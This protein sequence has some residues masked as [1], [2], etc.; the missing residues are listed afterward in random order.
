MN[1]LTTVLKSVQKNERKKRQAQREGAAYPEYAT[2]VSGES[3]SKIK[4]SV[5]LTECFMELILQSKVL[6]GARLSPMQKAEIVQLVKEFQPGEVCLALGDG[7][8]D[9][10]MLNEAHIGVSVAHSNVAHQLQ[11]GDCTALNLH[12]DYS[13]GQFKHLKT[14][15]LQHGRESYR[16]NTYLIFFCIFKNLLITFPI[17]MHAAVSGFSQSPLYP[18]E[19]FQLFNIAFTCLPLL[20]FGLQDLE[21]EKEV[22]MRTPALYE[23]GQ[24]S[25]E[26]RRPLFCKWLVICF[27]LSGS[28]FFACFTCLANAQEIP[29][30][31]DPSASGGQMPDASMISFVL[32]FS[33]VLIANLKLLADQTSH[34]LLS[35]SASLLSIGAFFATV[36]LV[37]SPEATY[38]LAQLAV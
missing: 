13:L 20:A 28:A 34:D 35:V 9:I 27:A 3:F 8:N 23:D 18:D 10:C 19:L 2:L 32:T 11:E 12:A 6:I 31:A 24:R 22:Y 16:R 37:S 25:R 5:R 29:G 14:L 1:Y 33:I 21:Y 7:I 15:L 17:A 4:E 26:F 36:F 30:G 38:S